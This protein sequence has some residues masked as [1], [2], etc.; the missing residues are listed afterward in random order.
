MPSSSLNWRPTANITQLKQRSQIL[1]NIRQF[2][3]KRNVWE[4]E[5]PL[6][7]HSTATDPH[8][9][10]LVVP[11]MDGKNPS[12]FYLQT[13]PEFAM[14]RLLAAGSG[15]IYQISKAFRA[16][17]KGR[18]HHTE[19]TLLEWYRIG[20]D[21]HQL[22]DEMDA[23]LHCVLQTKPAER[24]SY[25]EIFQRYLKMDPLLAST[26]EL[27]KCAHQQGL[28]ISQ[29]VDEDDIDFWRHLLMSHFIEPHLGK[30]WPVFITDFPASQA[31][32]ARIR[33][34][35]PPVA[36]RFEVY[37]Q[38][39]ELANG[40][41]ELSDAA[42]QKRRFLSDNQR[43]Q[44]LG[45][46]QIPMDEY[47]LAALEHGFPNCAGVALG[48]DRLIMLALKENTIEHVISFR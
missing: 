21:H 34:D 18:L 6:L 31:A 48:I 33:H 30:D 41:H 20:F 22:M 7:A 39:I 44:E 2:F 10:S 29:T 26:E 9:G 45:L 8:I 12:T 38:G 16:E 17:E 1:A 28:S 37:F 43:R 46:P 14:K 5:T 35:N 23:L 3:A 32:L 13:S 24:L 11:I 25:Q 15:S 19:F 47:L 42:E 36:E 27:I 40:Y 4:V